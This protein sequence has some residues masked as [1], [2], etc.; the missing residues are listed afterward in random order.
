MPTIAS[1]ACFTQ[2]GLEEARLLELVHN[3][4]RSPRVSPGTS[5]QL[6]RAER[7][8]IVRLLRY[9]HDAARVA[10]E[11][12][13]VIRYQRGM[14]A[15]RAAAPPRAT[16]LIAALRVVE[17]QAAALLGSLERLDSR[18]RDLLRVTYETTLV[19]VDHVTH[20]IVRENRS[21]NDAADRL[22]APADTSLDELCQQLERAGADSNGKIR[23]S[24][25]R[26]LDVLSHVRKVA[27]VLQTELRV[28]E[29][30]LPDAELEG[31]GSL[32]RL[33]FDKA[34]ETLSQIFNRY[35]IGTEDGCDLNHR[36]FSF[37]RAA[38][39]AGGIPAPGLESLARRNLRR[40]D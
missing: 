26:L 12:Q 2:D 39:E 14:E 15:L 10:S 8:R 3:P 20:A 34:A 27:A 35:Q 16:Q 36:R 22:S 19:S 31:R 24:W 32:P 40:R 11:L 37:V 29:D 17:T 13:T 23:L 7:A 21:V 33:G 6:P 18:S 28:L 1:L 38:F 9:E 5:P 4:L 25:V 30:G